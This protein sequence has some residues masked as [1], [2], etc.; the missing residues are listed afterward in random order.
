M[1]DSS[2]QTSWA[3]WYCMFCKPL[4]IRSAEEAGADPNAG[5]FLTIYMNPP[6]CPYVYVR[7]KV[8]EKKPY[9]RIKTD[10]DFC[11]GCS[12][13]NGNVHHIGCALE[14]CPKCHDFLQ[15]CSC[16]DDVR[17]YK[18]P[19]DEGVFADPFA[20][21]ILC[22]ICNIPRQPSSF[23]IKIELS[24]DLLEW[25]REFCLYHNHSPLYDEE[26]KQIAD[27]ILTALD[28]NGNNDGYG[29][30]EFN[31]HTLLWLAIRA[32]RCSSFA[33]NAEPQLVWRFVGR[34]NKILGRNTY[35]YR[36]TGDGDW[37]PVC[38][39]CCSE[40]AQ[41]F[42]KRKGKQQSV[43]IPITR[44]FKDFLADI[45]PENCYHERLFKQLCSVKGGRIILTENQAI[46]LKYI[47]K[48][49][50]EMAD[51]EAES[52]D[53]TDMDIIKRDTIMENTEEVFNILRSAVVDDRDIL[54]F[55]T[56][57]LSDI[58]K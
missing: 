33:V 39:N 19:N 52:D 36:L 16:C 57:Y 47:I 12:V 23:Q 45:K 11:P 14:R 2:S 8:E 53:H 25:L 3:R 18:S 46:E 26:T 5:K 37:N 35:P 28:K 31:I 32:E 44:R 1:L 4:K 27:T 42:D 24:K 40:P 49:E 34:L 9:E 41:H 29:M 58:L 6:T 55:V 20:D 7:L 43:T 30:I 38:N 22:K 54:K 56:V 21:P 17:Y 13:T 51:Q 10:I 48:D 15:T 50:R